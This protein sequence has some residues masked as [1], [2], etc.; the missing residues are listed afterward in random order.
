VPAEVPYLFA[1]EEL[2]TRWAQDLGS[3]PGFKI[4]VVWQGN[5]HHGWDH[6]RSFP[7][8][9]LA[10]LAKVPGVRLYS[11]QRGPGAEQLAGLN[12]QF[13]VT[14]L[15]GRWAHPFVSLRELAAVMVS[16]DLVVTADTAPVHLAGALGVPV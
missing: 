9:K 13:M 5:P 6:F 1:E 7:L 11:L 3:Q 15:V 10:P 14:D 12:G 2:V 8:V 16:L 4:G